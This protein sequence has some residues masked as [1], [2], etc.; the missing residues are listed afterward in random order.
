MQGLV[1]REQLH[2]RP[3]SPNSLR[4]AVA[5]V[6]ERRTPAG[7]WEEEEEEEQGGRGYWEYEE[8]RPAR[9]GRSPGMHVRGVEQALEGGGWGSLSARPASLGAGRADA[10]AMRSQEA[11]ERLKSLLQE[12]VERWKVGVP[13]RVCLHLHLD[14]K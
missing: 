10:A 7:S 13:E 12:V 2:P 6:L 4:R 14:T 3:R 8:E 11:N 9:R 5:E 1:H